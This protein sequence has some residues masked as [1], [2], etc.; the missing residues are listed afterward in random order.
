M[1]RPRAL[2]LLSVLLAAT[3]SA[4][5]LPSSPAASRCR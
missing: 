1:R 2:P 5:P 3:A 4:A